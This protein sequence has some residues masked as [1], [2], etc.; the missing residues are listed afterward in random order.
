MVK[1]KSEIIDPT[2]YW[3]QQ[4]A[5]IIGAGPAGLMAAEILSQGGVQVAV[6]D[7]MPS[8]GRKFLL[9]GKGGLNITHSEPIESFLSRYGSRRPQ[10]E[11]LLAD[12]GPDELRD[13][14]HKLGISTFI[15][16]SGRIF[17]ADMKA[18]PLLRT[19]INRLK[20][21]GVSFHLQHRWLG[22]DNDSSLKFTTP[23]AEKCVFADA[24][25]LALGGG[26][27]PEL[28]SDGGWIPLLRARGVE[29]TD[30]Q[31]ANCGFDVGWSDH[32]RQRFAGHPV[33]TAVLH[34]KQFQQRGEFI[35]TE[36]GVEGSLIYAASA[37][38]RD[39][40][41][42]KGSASFHLDLAPDKSE[43]RLRSRLAKPQGSRSM[44][45]HLQSRIR[46]K[47]VKVGLLRE[48]VPAADFAH[49]ERLAA[50]IKALPIHL[51]APRPLNEAISS[52]G[53]IPFTS[54]NS[55]LMLKNLPAVFCAG[56]MLDWEAPTGG[57]LLTACF[58]SGRTAGLGALNWLQKLAKLS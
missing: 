21:A 4:Q 20:T 5:A 31:P 36:T 42:A 45:S 26:S 14:V 10:I 48:I 3:S 44:S 46:L 57:Y 34:F 17:P 16:S 33:K 27:R 15:G 9:A 29:V 49:P 58:A 22:W 50:A 28:G 43:A 25:V 6:Y 35:I 37:L 40:I 52:A 54:M 7:G 8:V 39:E 30:L 23:E 38:L 1:H 53:G 51:I 24:T 56:E 12:F 19:W 2:D 13:W 41:T 18:A 11:P 32:F 55:S 47:G